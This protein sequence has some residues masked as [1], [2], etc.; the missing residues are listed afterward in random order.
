M[1]DEPTQLPAL[2][3][4]RSSYEKGRIYRVV[5]TNMDS[6]AYGPIPDES[7]RLDFRRIKDARDH[8]QFVADK[9]DAHVPII[10]YRLRDGRGV[11]RELYETA[12]PRG[13]AKPPARP[14]CAW[15]PVSKPPTSGGIYVGFLP[16]EAEAE[17]R[18]WPVSFERGKWFT[19]AG[20][21]LRHKVTHWTQMMSPPARG[22]GN[23]GCGCGNCGCGRGAVAGATFYEPGL[24]YLILPHGL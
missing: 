15:H 12:A 2:A 10:V 8:A 13:A 20:E 23:C 22:R 16:G 4:G 6:D 9:Y 19:A 14:D 1:T 21:R 18:V 3:I 24:R 11:H 5:S 17:D 7:L